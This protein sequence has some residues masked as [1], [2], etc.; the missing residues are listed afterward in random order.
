MGKLFETF[1]KDTKEV[2]RHNDQKPREIFTNVDD[3]MAYVK[4]TSFRSVK[5]S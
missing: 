2:T 3:A 1:R 4:S 5:K